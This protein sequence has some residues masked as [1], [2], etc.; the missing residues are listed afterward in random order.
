MK[1][2]ISNENVINEI[3]AHNVD[4]Y[5]DSANSACVDIIKCIDAYIDNTKCTTL[6][7]M[8]STLIH[9]LIT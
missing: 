8:K 4:I 2:N 5:S 3:I 7:I 6:V 1:N 9:I